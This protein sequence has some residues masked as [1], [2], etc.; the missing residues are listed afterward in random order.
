[1]VANG[2]NGQ[3]KAEIKR[4]LKT[5]GLPSGKLNSEL[6]RLIESLSSQSK[7]SL[8]LANGIWYQNE[9]TLKSGFVADN[10]K[11]FKAE[12]CGLD[13]TNPISAD[14]IND[15]AAQK[16]RG[17][18]RNVVQ[19]PFE[20][21]TK[22][23]LASAIYFKG[24]WAKPFDKSRTE[25]RP[26]YIEDGESRRVSMMRRDGYFLYRETD[27]FQAVRLLY[28]GWNFEMIVFLPQTNST[29]QKLLANFAASWLYFSS[30]F[31][32]RDGKLVIP[33][34]KIESQV[35]LNEALKAM[36]MRIA[37]EAGADLSAM[38][39][40]QLRVSQVKQQ[41]FIEVNE[42]GTEA[43]AHTGVGFSVIGPIRTP[44]PPF[45]M[46]VDRPFLFVIT[47]LHTQSILFMG[48]VSDP[49][50]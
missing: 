47:D 2:A 43:A 22:L 35:R 18:V 34:F 10:Q 50:N 45:E 46:I 20:P 49:G 25:S 48:I 26:F 11:Y 14:V 15:W 38:S 23:I 31:D 12:L 44:P 32:D 36:G 8:S 37:F 4:V 24:K 3:T 9:L 5:D 1:M 27:D 40:N 29:P 16:T 39:D 6:R 13:F 41:S 19:F 7:V 21:D 28:S 30:Q 17:S 42:D 33:K